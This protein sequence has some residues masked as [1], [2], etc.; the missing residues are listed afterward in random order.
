MKRSTGVTVSAVL[1]FIGSGLTL[2]F[3]GLLGLGLLLAMKTASESAPRGRYFAVFVFFLYFILGIFGVATG[4][5][6]LLVRQWARISMLAFS[7]ILLCLAVSALLTVPFIPTPQS[8]NSPEHLALVAKVGIGAFLGVII[9]VSGG[10]LLFFNQ[11]TVK[12]QFGSSP[13]SALPVVPNE[14]PTAP[15]GASLALLTPA[16]RLRPVS[17]TIIGWLMVVSSILALPTLLLRYPHF[18]FAWLL[19]GWR[20]GLLLFVRL[21]AECIAG[22]G[23][24][25]LRPWARILAISVF[26]FSLLNGG[27]FVVLP[28]RIDR[29]ERL[30]VA[31]QDSIQA[32]SGHTTVKPHVFSPEMRR[33]I[34]ISILFV[35]LICIAVELWFVVARKEAFFPEPEAPPGL[36]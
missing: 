7:G 34:Q 12:E 24:L 3:T 6:L 29:F 30:H 16:P 22:V 9:I 8:A 35:S 1:V 10:W 13:A 23:L 31:M 28:G 15:V 27:A 33:Y 17:I 32:R 5:G 19:T 26:S 36:S 11:S 25:R 20:A 18:V 14:N 2:L 21:A 4:I